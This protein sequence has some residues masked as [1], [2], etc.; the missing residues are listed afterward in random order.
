MAPDD[1]ECE[2]VFRGAIVCPG[3]REAGECRNELGSDFS[4]KPPPFE[5]E[6]DRLPIDLLNGTDKLRHWAERGG[7]FAELEKLESATLGEYLNRREDCLL[8]R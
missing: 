6:Y 5:Y 7:T 3:C 2:V 1:Q 8:Y 4:W